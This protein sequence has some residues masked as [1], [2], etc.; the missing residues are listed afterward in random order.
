[1]APEVL[2]CG[3]RVAPAESVPAAEDFATGRGAVCP[4]SPKVDVWALGMLLL[5][6]ALVSS[7]YLTVAAQY[8]SR[9][10]Q[11][12][13]RAGQYLSRAGQYLAVAPK[14]KTDTCLHD[15]QHGIN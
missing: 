9:A 5:E 14:H 7:Q 11:Y 8:L 3:A 4:L 6:Q 2:V 12:L 10:G 1:M 13:S 15:C